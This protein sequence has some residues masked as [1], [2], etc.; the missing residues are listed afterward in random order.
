MTF[1]TRAKDEAIDRDRGREQTEIDS[2]T[3]C[4]AE[5]ETVIETRPERT[6]GRR[7]KGPEQV[8]DRE[9]L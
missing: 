3:R 2:Q 7:R 6:K 1:R 9:S 5:P 4:K 8:T